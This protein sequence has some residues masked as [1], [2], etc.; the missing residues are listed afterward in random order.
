MAFAEL[1]DKHQLVYLDLLG[2]LLELRVIDHDLLL[3]RALVLLDNVLQVPS[4]D[5]YERLVGYLPKI[6]ARLNND[7]I[8]K[9]IKLEAAKGCSAVRNWVPFIGVCALEVFSPEDILVD[10]SRPL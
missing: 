1:F 7:L 10:D 9:P 2:E 3:M 6:A 4:K 5:F 8:I